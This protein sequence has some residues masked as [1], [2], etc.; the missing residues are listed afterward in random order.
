MCMQRHMHAGIYAVYHPLQYTFQY[1]LITFKTIN[2]KNVL[3]CSIIRHWKSKTHLKTK[4][5]KFSFV[6]FRFCYFF[7][8]MEDCIHVNHVEIHICVNARTCNIRSLIFARPQLHIRNAIQ[9]HM[10]SMSMIMLIKLL[11]TNQCRFIGLCVRIKCVCVC[12]FNGHRNRSTCNSISMANC[13]FDFVG[14]VADVLAGSCFGV[15]L[16][17]LDF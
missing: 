10:I 8:D 14:V 13:L 6:C 7:L 3:F 17:H 15:Y 1:G 12:I 4:L 16:R 11:V 9:L 2:H 5:L